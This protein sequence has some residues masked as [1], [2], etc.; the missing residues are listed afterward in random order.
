MMKPSSKTSSLFLQRHPVSRSQDTEA[1]AWAGK[2]RGRLPRRSPPTVRYAAM[3]IAR[4]L[5]IQT[6][7]SIREINAFWT[8][9]VGKELAELTRPDRLQAGRTG[10]CLKIRVRG[11][12]AVLIESQSEKIIARARQYSGRKI[13]RLK[14][15]QDAINADFALMGKPSSRIVKSHCVRQQDNSLNALL[16][17]WA[18]A[19]AKPD[20][21]NY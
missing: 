12:A 1:W 11:P 19:I 8:E 10:S 5:P 7:A 9:I 20:Q 18:C 13:T 4:R 15:I 2:N 3:K 6:H 14:I 16:D 17:A 21:S